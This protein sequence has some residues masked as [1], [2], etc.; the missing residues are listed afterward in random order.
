MAEPLTLSSSD[1]E[2]TSSDLENPVEVAPVPTRESLMAKHAANRA[3]EATA[4]NAAQSGTARDSAL[5]RGAGGLAG[6]IPVAGPAL[7]GG[8]DIAAQMI[9]KTGGQRQTYNPLRTA[10]EVGLSA[11]PGFGVSKLVKP[12]TGIVANAG[13]AA[14][15]T[16][17]H[18]LEGA[19]RGAGATA[20]TSLSEGEIPTGEQ[21]YSGAAG[22]A[23]L[24][25]LA[26]VF[27]LNQLRR[28]SQRSNAAY[29]AA[30]HVAKAVNLPPS[31]ERGADTLKEGVA[32]TLSHAA[33]TRE[34]LKSLRDLSEASEE[35]RKVFGQAHIDPLK[36]SFGQ[37]I[38]NPAPILKRAERGLE[39]IHYE[40]D[41]RLE[42][43]L[44]TAK[45]VLS[46]PRTAAELLEYYHTLQGEL[47]PFYKAD[48][49]ER[50][51]KFGDAEWRFKLRLK[52]ELQNK[53]ADHFDQSR[54]LQEGTTTDALRASGN[55]FKSIHR[56][57]GSLRMLSDLSK[58]ASERL[59]NTRMVKSGELM[60]PA[61]VT[62]K[63]LSP[64]VLSKRRMAGQALEMAIGGRNDPD[65]LVRKA[66][67]VFSKY[68]TPAARPDVMAQP[69]IDEPQPPTPGQTVPLTIAPVPE[70][71]AGAQTGYTSTE[72]LIPMT[73]ERQALWSV[74]ERQQQALRP[75]P[76]RPR[77]GSR[78]S[79]VEEERRRFER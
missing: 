53:L 78:L 39:D 51:L 9:E 72:S 44:K 49:A 10:T 73:P 36:E 12:T 64:M 43:N 27:S 56:Q 50:A 65:N 32:L 15:I 26:S 71:P 38:I 55:G 74:A 23:L 37:Q 59:D 67:K 41:P 11:V 24:S 14:V 30:S 76:R 69:A 2:L 25:P 33:N 68:G 35:A 5:V 60:S 57:Y 7:A 6:M 62:S 54:A 22:G 8:A 58:E 18:A 31:L 40:A 47:Q 4:Y 3:A 79:S 20:V 17:A 29:N 1:L 63:V 34:P 70:P 19:A 21:L 28:A 46:R 61:V 45:D 48:P 42:A 16:G 52:D 66:Q 77:T 13:R 75:P